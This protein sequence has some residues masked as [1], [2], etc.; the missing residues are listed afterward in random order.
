MPFCTRPRKPGATQ[1]GSGRN[2]CLGQ[3]VVVLA[4]A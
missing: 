3:I 1:K 2:R 4:P